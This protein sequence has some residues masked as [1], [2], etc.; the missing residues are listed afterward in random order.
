MYGDNSVKLHFL[1]NFQKPPGWPSKPPDSFP[2][3]PKM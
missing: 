1:E 2:S 3:N